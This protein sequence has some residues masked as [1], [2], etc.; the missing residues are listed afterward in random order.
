MLLKQ[1]KLKVS[2]YLALALSPALLLVP[3]LIVQHQRDHLK[4]EMAQ[5]V[6]QTA[7]V[8]VRSTRHAMLLN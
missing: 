5:H 1:I 2:L 4:V 6:V 3:F 8:V 7:E